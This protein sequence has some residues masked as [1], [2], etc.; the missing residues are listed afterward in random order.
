MHEDVKMLQNVTQ[1][2]WVWILVLAKNVIVNAVS[3]CIV[4]FS[5]Y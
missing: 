3:R 1:L 4:I 5:S 2:L